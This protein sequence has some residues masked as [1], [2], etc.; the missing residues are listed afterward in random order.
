MD[1]FFIVSREAHSITRTIKEAM[2]I[3]VNDLSLIRNLG[4]F[5]VPHIW[6]EV[7]QDIAVLHLK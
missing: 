2:F 5:Q 3:G 1:S 4:K 7:L 6:D